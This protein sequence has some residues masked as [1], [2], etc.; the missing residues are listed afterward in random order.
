MGNWTRRIC[1]LPLVLVVAGLGIGVGAG[2][3]ATRAVTPDPLIGPA[4]LSGD[5]EL[6]G[7]GRLSADQ[8]RLIGADSNA[9]FC[10]ELGTAESAN[11]S[12]TC[13]FGVETGEHQLGVAAVSD[14]TEGLRVV[15]GLATEAIDRV[16]VEL[17]NGSRRTVQLFT[18]EGLPEAT[19]AYL[20]EFE[21]TAL[22][23]TVKGLGPDGQ[24]VEMHTLDLAPST[25]P[26]PDIH[27]EQGPEDHEH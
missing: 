24:V 22:P 6:V 25:P 8:W 7:A 14:R 19:S 27:I 4:T 13:G 9:G 11:T 23:V 26:A 1:I 20:M 17:S 5:H 10:L 3:L 2:L 21:E 16:E 12:L 15:Y 18:A